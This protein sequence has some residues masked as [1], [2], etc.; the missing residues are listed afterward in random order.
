MT[1]RVYAP[2]GEP[3]DI[4]AHREADLLLY[5]GFSRTPHDPNAEPIVQDVPGY[6]ALKQREWEELEAERDYIA[7]QE[8]DFGALLGGEPTVQPIEEEP[9]PRP[10]RRRKAAA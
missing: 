2:D 1:V 3:F 9:K 8:I 10:R 5:K 7:G 4:P 6:R